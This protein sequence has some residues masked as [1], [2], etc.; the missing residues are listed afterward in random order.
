MEFTRHIRHVD[1]PAGDYMLEAELFYETRNPPQD[2]AS[3]NFTIP[4]ADE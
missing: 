4:E 1:D 3:V 2:T